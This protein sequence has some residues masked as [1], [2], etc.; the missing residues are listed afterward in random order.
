M[1]ASPPLNRREQGV[2]DAPL[3]GA[4]SAVLGGAH[5][6]STPRR[7][8]EVWGGPAM[9]MPHLDGAA[10]GVPDKPSEWTRSGREWSPPG[11]IVVIHG[12]GDHKEDETARELARALGRTLD[13]GLHWTQPT[14]VTH[15][16]AIQSV[17]QDEPDVPTFTFGAY[18]VEVPALGVAGR[19]P[20]YEFYWSKLSRK[21]QGF[22]GELQRSWQFL[23]GLPRV[24]YQALVP[25]VSGRAG[26]LMR[27]VRP[28]FCLAWVLLILRLICSL[29]LIFA[30]LRAE[31]H[32]VRLS[33]IL[34]DKGL[35]GIPKDQDFDI[36]LPNTS[37]RYFDVLLPIDLTIGLGFLAFSGSLGWLAVTDK[38]A[39]RTA[40]TAALCLTITTILTTALPYT[41][42]NFTK[43]TASLD[44]HGG[45]TG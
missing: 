18:E 3:V 30:L 31:T 22:L 12:V 35:P 28:I 23:A 17:T 43:T 25:A 38:R 16:G 24:G 20:V 9:S 15:H 41:I 39:L 6:P 34:Q 26:G 2:D 8:R 5:P 42:I 1:A 36:S 44:A 37:V 14:Y 11:A 32:T 45:E 10:V 7:L 29:A 13:P 19:I 40:A 4:G 27:V 33:T 21:G